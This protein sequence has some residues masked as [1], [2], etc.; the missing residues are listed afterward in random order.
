MSRKVRL[1]AAATYIFILGWLYAVLTEKDAP[2]VRF[3]LK[4]SV[5]LLLVLLLVAGGW[6]GIT[7]LLAWIPYAGILIGVMA[8]ALVIAAW[9]AGIFSWILGIVRALQGRYA[10]L[11]LIGQWAHR[12]PL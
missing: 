4:Q 8:F 6:Y 10:A 1:T 2:L 3:H 9:V 12:L 7:W 5:G 11:P